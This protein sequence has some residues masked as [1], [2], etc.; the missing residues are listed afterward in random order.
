MGGIS[1][2]SLKYKPSATALVS[3]TKV[4]WD[5]LL[6]SWKH[7]E[8]LTVWMTPLISFVGGDIVKYDMRLGLT[9]GDS[10]SG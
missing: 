8:D 5:I 7:P 3:G 6:V 9:G 4:K 1:S 2:N 10:H